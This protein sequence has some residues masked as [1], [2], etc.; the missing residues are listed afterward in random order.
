MLY[1]LTVDRTISVLTSSASF[2]GAIAIRA[3]PD[4]LK[5]VRMRIHSALWDPPIPVYICI[6]QTGSESDSSLIDGCVKLTHLCEDSLQK[7]GLSD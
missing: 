6:F 7:I 3:Q 1:S 2:I 5:A 4:E